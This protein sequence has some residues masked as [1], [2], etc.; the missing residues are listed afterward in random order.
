MSQ[1]QKKASGMYPSGTTCSSRH[2]R[3][4][5]RVKKHGRDRARVNL[6]WWNYNSSSPMMF[7]IKDFARSTITCI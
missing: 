3:G 7:M 6:I 4:S 1:A 2:R 5:L